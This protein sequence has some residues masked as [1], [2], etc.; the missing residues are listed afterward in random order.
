MHST[1]DCEGHHL[2]PVEGDGHP[3]VV[4]HGKIHLLE[5]AVSLLN[6]NLSALDEGIVLKHS[7]LQN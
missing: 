3:L 2:G 4:P 6:C 1:Q 5:A 7:Q